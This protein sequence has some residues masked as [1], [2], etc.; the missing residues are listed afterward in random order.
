M[1]YLYLISILFV[2]VAASAQ[3]NIRFLSA[4]SLKMGKPLT[5]NFLYKQGDDTAWA[6]PNYDDG[7]WQQIESSWLQKND[8][9]I[10]FDGICW[11]RQRVVIDSSLAGIPLT[12]NMRHKG[13]SEVYIDGK[14]IKSYGKIGTDDA[15]SKYYNP[16]NEPLA[17]HFDTAGLHTIAVRYANYRD[18]KMYNSGI[19]GVGFEMSID[20]AANGIHE[21]VEKVVGLSKLLLLFSGFF[22][23]LFFVHLLLWLYHKKDKSNLYYS[24][25]SLI[26]SALFFFGYSVMFST[27]TRFSQW[28]FQV[29][30][31]CNAMLFLSLSGLSN[32]LFSKRKLRFYIIAVLCLLPVLFLLIDLDAAGFILA[33][34]LGVVI[35]EVIVLTIVAIY[36]KQRGARIIGAGVLFFAGFLVMSFLIGLFAP[37]GMQVNTASGEGVINMV[38][39]FC[40]LLSIPV[41]MSVYLAWTFASTNKNLSKQLVNVQELSA[42][43]LEQEQEKKRILETQNE[44]LEQQVVERTQEI[45]TEKQKSDDLLRNIL[46]EEIAEELKQKGSSEAR[47]YDHVSVLFTDFVGFTKAG[48][49]MTPQELV[50]ELDTCFKEFDRITAKY[51]IEKIKTIGDAY[52]AVSGLPTADEHHATNTVQAAIEILEYMRVRQQEYPNKTFDIRIGIHSGAVVAG[53][54]GVKKFAYD[55]WGDTVNTAARME[56]SSEPN[57]INIS[58]ATYELVRDKYTCTYRGEVI[59][60]NKGEMEMYFVAGKR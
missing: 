53:I 5:F 24:I 11:F 2:T 21:F 51:D 19:S 48:E 3:E 6:N 58:L 13:A 34:A 9:S 57:K 7:G 25:F 15:S 14:Q 47:Y 50:N 59:A 27:D 44:R 17:I 38:L 41:S 31:I 42:R 18:L 35:I 26:T 52:L 23:A 22:V 16:R 39:T 8:D 20:N 37:N 55:I 12:L 4:D 29:T 45:V 28:G 32:E 1:R 40:A 10:V 30:I 56:S 43:T 36:R 60:K 46:P 33:V 49:R 54:V